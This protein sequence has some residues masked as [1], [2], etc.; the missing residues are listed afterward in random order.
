MAEAIEPRPGSLPLSSVLLA[1]LLVAGCEGSVVAVF[2]LQPLDPPAVRGAAEVDSLQPT[3]RWQ[4]FNPDEAFGE[5]VQETRERIHNITYE[6]KIWAGNNGRPGALI[7][8]RRGLAVPF[9]SLEQP[10]SAMSEYF[11]SVRARFELGGKTRVTE[12]S[13]RLVTVSPKN[14]RR[15][16]IV[17]NPAFLHFETP[18]G[19]E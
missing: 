17:P 3:F 10:L 8:Q 5:D 9:H 4:P 19:V 2:G 14:T 6:F 18:E 7:Y 13:V 11:W 1:V 16:P 15:S 12:W